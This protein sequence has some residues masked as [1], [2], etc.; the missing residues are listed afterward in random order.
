MSI[1]L[2]YRYYLVHLN[3]VADTVMPSRT[4]A[5][6]SGLH[7]FFTP[8]HS[9]IKR[10]QPPS[11]ASSLSSSSSFL[12]PPSQKTRT[13]KPQK[14]LTLTGNTI[15]EDAGDMLDIAIADMIHSN[16]LSFSIAECATFMRVIDIA[17]H[18]G[19][20]YKPPNRNDIGGRL[21]D[22]LYDSSWSTSM[23]TLLQESQIFGVTVFGDGA[24]IKSNALI[25][26][27]AAGV[28]NPSALLDVYDCTSHCALGGKKD[29]KFIA[30]VVE[31]F[32]IRMENETSTTGKH[33][34]GI[35]DMV[36]FDG[37]GNVQNA[38]KYLAAKHPRIT[39]GHGAEHVVSL[40]FSDVFNKIPEYRMLAN[41]CK[42]CRDIWGA[43]RHLPAAMFKAQSKLHNNGI[44]VGRY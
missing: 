31:P 24:T 21:L 3:C 23:N 4:T 40:F 41:F 35:V 37:A 12:V 22:T 32:I 33:C 16:L 2:L 18:C 6:G 36:F 42:S 9:S 43:T 25:N 44:H 39:V 15:N 5:S 34:T 10:K 38:G 27:L 7:S 14:Q 1:L 11:G 20:G 29:A 17:R 30:Q 28:N 19:P 13:G 8:N 26:V